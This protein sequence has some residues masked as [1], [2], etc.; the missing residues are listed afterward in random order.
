MNWEVLIEQ[1]IVT[2]ALALG[3]NTLFSL[4]VKSIFKKRSDSLTAMNHNVHAGIND[5]TDAVKSER[6]ELKE[7]RNEIKELKN[8][9]NEVIKVV[10]EFNKRQDNR[11]KQIEVIMNGKE[12]KAL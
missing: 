10:G 3:A 2:G 6:G 11:E 5:I 12:K 8:S 1:L 7:L 9:L 4:I